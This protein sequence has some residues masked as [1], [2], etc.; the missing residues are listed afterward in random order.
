MQAVPQIAM[1]W[2]ASR[3]LPGRGC[4]DFMPSRFRTKP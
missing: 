4:V 3:E 1:N 2:S